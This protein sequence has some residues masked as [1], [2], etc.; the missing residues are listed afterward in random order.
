M[1]SIQIS[2]V[3]L[4]VFEISYIYS[5]ECLSFEATLKANCE[6]ISD[7]TYKC[8][9]S[10]G[11]CSSVYKSCSAYKEKNQSTCESIIP[12][13]N[14][15]KCE[16]KDDVCTEVDK[17][18]DD[19]ES[20]LVCSTLK[21]KNSKKRC[22]LV[23]DKCQ[24][25]FN[26]CADFTADENVDSAKCLLN[27]PS[28]FLNK[29][30]WESNNCKDIPKVCTDFIEIDNL[31]IC[32]GKK[33]S[34]DTNKICLGKDNKCIEQYKTCKLYNDHASNKNENDCES[35]MIYDDTQAEFKN[36][37]ICQFST[38]SVC[39]EIPKPCSY[40]K[41]K[42]SCESFVPEDTDK[43]C[44]FSDDGCKEQYKKCDLYNKKA[45]N[46]NKNDCESIVIY[47][48]SPEAFNYKKICKFSESV[49]AE[50]TKE[51]SDI[52]DEEECKAFFPEDRDKI[53]IFSGNRCL[54]QYKTCE[55]YNTK[56]TE[57][58]K[59]YCESIQIY[60]SGSFV[61]NKICKFSEGTCVEKPQECS[62]LDE[63]LCNAQE[64]E[65]IKKKCILV[66]NKCQ[67]QYKTCEIYNDETK[68]ECEKILPYVVD[69]TS[70]DIYSN[71]VFNDDDHSCTR[72]KKPCSEFKD[73][74]SC[75]LQELKDS[76][77]R[78]I[79]Y[80]GQCK[81]EY[82]SCTEYNSETNKN[83]E[84]CKSIILSNPNAIDYLHKCI[85]DNK[86]ACVQ[87]DKTC[88]DYIS[89]QSEEFCT[90][91][92]I[93]ADKRC[94][95]IN[96]KCVEQ[97]TDCSYNDGKDKNRCESIV[98]SQDYLKCELDKDY[99]CVQKKRECSEY[100]GDSEYSCENNYASR[101]DNKK[102]FFINNKCTEKYIYCS[103][104]KGNDKETC[105]SIKPYDQ[106]GTSALPGYKCVFGTN[107]CERVSKE[108]TDAKSATECYSISPTDTNKNCIYTDN[109]CIE[110]Y[111]DCDTYNNNAKTIEENVCKS[112]ILRDSNEGQ[113]CVFTAGSSG[114]AN[115]C[116]MKPKVC[117]DYTP[118]LF[119]YECNLIAP[120]AGKKCL[121]SNSQCLEANKSC[122]ELENDSTVTEAICS[123]ANVSD[124]NKKCEIKEDN[125][126]C[127]EVNKNGS[128]NGGNQ[129]NNEGSMSKFNLLLI[130]FALFLN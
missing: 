24:S 7:D 83:E 77:K 47:E 86:D 4:F 16:L 40:F 21:D 85:Y 80:G 120:G 15:K 19:Y 39:E 92:V 67:E 100:T 129:N 99:N 71:C 37:K 9:Y 57:K 64:L 17:D 18:C 43:I 65:D 124:S 55:L 101:D 82:K 79:F 63:T 11:K 45:A 115:K 22:I 118:E 41:D 61:Y 27:I 20:G 50:K 91:I 5:A 58:N 70:L 1:K 35:I 2:I 126:G 127:K 97:D 103:A 48:G 30:T 89:G 76:K 44:I 88:E 12:T 14:Y 36:D 75:F 46:K 96:N 107:G 34:D 111:K 116:E 73:S 90:N 125:S 33:T 72:E 42:E 49:C 98:L 74:T 119:N 56:V 10:N 106:Y 130:I 128:E 109:K 68:A 81:E 110:Q 6:S 38:S 84:K 54:E 123:A 53:C 78:C 8:Q 26:S 114:A 121:F 87:D 108:C 32:N 31:N 51:C 117:S 28:D 59:D 29:C 95:F 104:Y 105:E 25:H 69:T 94:I 60:K 62:K 112:I 122:L 102:C 13:N 66:G 52:T 3:I 113:K 93:S 23:G